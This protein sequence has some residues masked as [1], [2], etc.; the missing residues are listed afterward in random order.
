MSL[1]SVILKNF[2]SRENHPFL[3]KLRRSLCCSKAEIICKTP[4]YSQMVVK[5][6]RYLDLSYR[7]NVSTPQDRDV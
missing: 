2:A 1:L 4:F 6:R 7:V 5:T 3:M